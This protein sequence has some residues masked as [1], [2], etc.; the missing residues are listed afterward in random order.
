MQQILTAVVVAWAAWHV[1][2]ALAPWHQRR[3][4]ATLARHAEGRL[5]ARLMRVLRPGD[6]KSGCGCGSAC[7]EPGRPASRTGP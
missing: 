7:T 2:G 6:F 3:L 4:R 1:Y 5:P